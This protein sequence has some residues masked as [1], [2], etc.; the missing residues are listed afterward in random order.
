VNRFVHVE[1]HHYGPRVFILG[2]RIHEWHLGLGILAVTGLGIAVRLWSFSWWSGAALAVGAYALAKDARD[3][4]AHTRDTGTWRLG[5]HVGFAPLRAIRYADG[6][7]SLAGAVAFGIGV[8]NLVSTLT[9]NIAWRGH[10]LLQ[11]VPIREIPVFHTLAVPASIALVVTAL[12]LRRRRR[13]ALQVAIALLLVLCVLNV[14]KGLDVEEAVLSLLGAALLWW[15]RGAFVVQPG[16]LSRRA[17]FLL[18]AVMLVCVS[19]AAELVWIAAG[20]AATPDMIAK[21][22]LQLFTWTEAASFHDELG[23]VPIAIDIATAAFIVA[24]G[25]ILFR[26][27]SVR[28]ELPDEPQRAAALKLV[29]TFGSDTLAFFKLRRDLHYLFTDDGHA[30]LGYRVE[31]DVLIVAGD[32]IGE[33]DSVRALVAKTV[34]FAE[35]RGLAIAVLG[36]SEELVSV[37]REARLRALYIGDEAIIETASFSLEGRAIRKVR[38]SVTRAEREGFRAEA[39]RLDALDEAT[40]RELERVSAA[41]LDGTPER[42]FAMAL[43]AIGG[44]EQEDSVIVLAR[45]G[46]EK[47]RAFL[48]FVPSYGRPAMSLSFMRREHGLPNGVT[49]FLVVRSIE[50]LRELGVEEISLNF[51]AFGRFLERPQ[52]TFERLLGKVVSLG[53]RYFQIESL[54][55]FNAKFAPRWEPRYLVFERLGA[56]PR[57]GLAA[58]TVEGQIQLPR[59]RS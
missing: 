38:Q 43:D 15:G 8:V 35:T 33:P 56:L 16:R 57:V 17:L 47:V 36:A 32:P 27:P 19:L 30:F 59:L 45:D 58:M 23:F 54:Y 2:R 37:W 51:A 11:L 22:T 9:P 41:W 25:A 14:L 12:Y 10:V 48:H 40:L 29:R 42:G 13:R 34:A 53:N 20:G 52:G 21:Q 49:E 18:G 24:A 7:P 46:E 50:L 4:R 6:L 5:R 44:G 1:L 39:Y 28:T 26:P 55:K 3:I 31:N